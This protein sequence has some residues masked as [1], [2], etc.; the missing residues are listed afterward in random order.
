MA[1]FPHSGWWS[2]L[3]FSQDEKVAFEKS[4]RRVLA[5]S[6]RKGAIYGRINISVCLKTD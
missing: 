5:P 1:F 3:A 6:A 2:L 4:E